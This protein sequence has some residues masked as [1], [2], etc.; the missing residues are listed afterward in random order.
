MAAAS[1]EEESFKGIVTFCDEN[2]ALVWVEGQKWEKE[3]SFAYRHRRFDLGDW[4]LIDS[5]DEI[6]RI[7]PC[8]ETR[9]LDVGIVQ[10]RLFCFFSC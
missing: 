4:V 7:E 9:V 1:P 6:Y 10:V 2:R 5:R 3:V 8:L